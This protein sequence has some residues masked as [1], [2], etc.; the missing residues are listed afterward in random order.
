MIDA[1]RAA[2]LPDVPFSHP[3]FDVDMPSLTHSFRDST[4]GRIPREGI[5]GAIGRRVESS[6]SSLI[7]PDIFK[8]VG[9][10]ESSG[11]PLLV[12]VWQSGFHQ[13]MTE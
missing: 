10:Y 9:S 11:Y 7:K 4:E 13:E 3:L 1:A 8:I 6:S 2:F 5:R 12:G